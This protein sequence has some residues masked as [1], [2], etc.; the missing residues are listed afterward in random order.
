MCNNWSVLDPE[1]SF[2]D[3]SGFFMSES[4]VQGSPI[5]ADFES[6]EYAIHERQV[7]QRKQARYY[8]HLGKEAMAYFLYRAGR[9]TARDVSAITRDVEL[10]RPPDLGTDEDRQERDSRPLP[11]RRP[12][13]PWI[14]EAV[15]EH[16]REVFPL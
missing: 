14:A 12:M 1:T 8:S 6:K 16:R 9:L 10:R 11:S 7:D 2:C 4:V 13:C 15:R 5:L 3:L